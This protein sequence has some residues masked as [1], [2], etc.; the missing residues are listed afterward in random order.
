M[1]EKKPGRAD[2]VRAAWGKEKDNPENK[3]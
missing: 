2:L 1:P 3:E